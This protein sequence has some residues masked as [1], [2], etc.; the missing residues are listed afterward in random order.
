[1]KVITC[2]PPKKIN[3]KAVLTLV[4]TLFVSAV[5]LMLPDTAIDYMKK[6]LLLCAHSLIP[7]LFPFMIISEIIV[8]CGIGQ[9]ISR[10][11]SPVF[12]RLFGIGDAGTCATVIGLLCGFPIGARCA[13][14]LHDRGE[15]STSEL[16]RTLMICNNASPAFVISTVGAAIMGDLRIGIV[17][18][19]CLVLSSLTVSLFAGMFMKKAELFPSLK[20]SLPSALGAKAFTDAVKNSV[21]SMLSVC[22]F[23][24]IFSTVVGCVTELIS[25]AG[26]PDTVL[27]FISGFFELSGGAVSASRL[28]GTLMRATASALF[29]SWSGLCVHFQIISAAGG[30]GASFTPYFVAKAIQGILCAALCAVCL[31]FIF[32]DLLLNDAQVFV[33]T[34][35]PPSATGTYVCLAFVLASSIPFSVYLFTKKRRIS[36]KK[37]IDKRS[38]L[39]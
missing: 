4:G 35:T 25:K 11:L 23:I 9:F 3:A 7:S 26:V 37:V 31:K 17:I 36:S 33:P 1:M 34:D 38:P 13:A 29:C 22:A 27:C 28:D 8:S 19:V 2:P 21:L 24:L 12:K 10:P 16:E 30:R 20:R 32:P 6:G 14:S 15:M 39:C 18:Y 5:L